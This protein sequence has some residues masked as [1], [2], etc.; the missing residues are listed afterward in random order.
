M[1]TKNKP[2]DRKPT[3]ADLRRQVRQFADREAAIL[4]TIAVHRRRRGLTQ[5]QAAARVGWTASM[6]SDLEH[7]RFSPRLQTILRI[8]HALNCTAGRLCSAPVKRR[9]LGR[10]TGRNKKLQ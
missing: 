1:T 3:A 2:A 7:G 9:P 6:W 8:A 10:V 4:A 5:A